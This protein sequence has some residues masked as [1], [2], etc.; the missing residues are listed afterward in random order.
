MA[1]TRPPGAWVP[2]VFP[3]AV[4][5]AAGPHPRP[6]LAQDVQ[7]PPARGLDPWIP[8]LPLT[9][10][11]EEHDGAS[12]W[13][14]SQNHLKMGVQP[15]KGLVVLPWDSQE[16]KPRPRVGREDGADSRIQPWPPPQASSLSALMAQQIP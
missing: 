8:V 6:F 2:T 7:E 13:E 14:C 1:V 9:G 15:C 10:P 16:V 4:W 3:V 11:G 5:D 12:G